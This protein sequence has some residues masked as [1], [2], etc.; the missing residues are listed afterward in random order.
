MRP[1][2]GIGTA[3]DNRPKRQKN[4]KTLW[5]I[6]AVA[7]LLVVLLPLV[8]VLVSPGQAQEVQDGLHI[9]DA[10]VGEDEAVLY[11]STA[12]MTPA[13]R[14]GNTHDSR[15]RTRASWNLIRLT[16]T[17]F[18]ALDELLLGN[19][20]S[21]ISA[22]TLTIPVPSVDRIRIGDSIEIGDEE[23]ELMRVAAIDRPTPPSR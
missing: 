10:P 6:R 11:R 12:R 8:A 19:L 4:A 1:L 2:A 3:P 16:R 17:R 14:L 5:S 22:S 9:L 13:F 23:G 20:E 15:E 7:W 18:P 21:S